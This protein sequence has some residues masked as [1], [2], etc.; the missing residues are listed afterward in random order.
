MQSADVWE[1]ASGT[2][3]VDMMRSSYGSFFQECTCRIAI[4]NMASMVIVM[5]EVAVA[6]VMVGLRSI[7]SAFELTF[8]LISR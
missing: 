7:E 3:T 6:A 5:K 4:L 1:P 8:R 2:G